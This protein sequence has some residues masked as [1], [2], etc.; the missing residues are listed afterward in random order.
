MTE[1]KQKKIIGPVTGASTLGAALGLVLS[2][3]LTLVG[4]EVP[5]PVQGAL[6]VLLC[7]LG[8]YLMPSGTGKRVA[9]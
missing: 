6:V 7:A 9:K 4:I 8:G 1:T 5:E 2:Y 3:L